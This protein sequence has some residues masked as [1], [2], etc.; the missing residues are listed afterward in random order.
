[1][2]SLSSGMSM[3]RPRI[4]TPSFSFTTARAYGAEAAWALGATRITVKL[5]IVPSPSSCTGCHSCAWHAGHSSFGGIA[6]SPHAPQRTAVN[7]PSCARSKKVR[8]VIAG[9]VTAEEAHEHGGGVAAEGVSQAGPCAVDL[10]RAGL[11]A[12]LRDDLRDLRSARRA[13]GMALRLQ[14]ARWIDRDLPPEAR[15][16][17]LGGAAA[18]ARLEE[19]EPFGGDD[20]GDREAVVQLDDGH[21]VWASVVP[22]F[23]MWARAISAKTPGK[24]RPSGCSQTASDA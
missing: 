10:A 14:T 17:L 24:V 7:C 12:Q 4:D 8:R 5:A 2:A 15:E 16:P 18:G 13:D 3:T 20:L 9:S 23:S 19:A 11:P 22:C 21:V 1:M 6:S